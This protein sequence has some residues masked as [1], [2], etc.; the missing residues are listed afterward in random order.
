MLRRNDYNTNRDFGYGGAKPLPESTNGHRKETPEE[1]GVTLDRY[2]AAKR[3][4]VWFLESINLNDTNY[5]F[6]PAV[7]IPYPDELGKEAYHRYRVS[8]RDEPR[9]KAPPKHVAPNPV[10]Y[11]LHLLGEARKAGYMWVTEG[12]SDTQVMWFIDEPAFGIPGVESWTKYGQEWAR[13]LHD[14]PVLLV[15]ADHDPAGENS[16]P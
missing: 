6:G 11:G 7:R 5:D 8:L 10:P 2:A 16:L 3:L 4:P 9:L 1:P 13:H 14:I 12:E 15:P